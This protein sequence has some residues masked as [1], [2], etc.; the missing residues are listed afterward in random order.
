M[1]FP[2]MKLGYEALG[3]AVVMTAAV[4]GAILVAAVVATLA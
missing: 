2:W 3:L 4:V 1:R